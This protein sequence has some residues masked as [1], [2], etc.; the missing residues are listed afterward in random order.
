MPL[1]C[2]SHCLYTL[3]FTAAMLTTRDVG[4]IEARK[5]SDIVMS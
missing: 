2:L 1:R 3:H 5:V 4:K